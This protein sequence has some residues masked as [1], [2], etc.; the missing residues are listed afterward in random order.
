VCIFPS[1]VDDIHIIGLA[2]IV[3]LAFDHFVFQL[4]LMGLMVQPYKYLAWSPSSLHLGFYR[5]IDFY[6]PLD[7]INVLGIPL[8][9]SY[10]MH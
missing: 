4:V 1:L 10:T 7:D 2:F 5:T 9:L 3:H 8:G 6:Y